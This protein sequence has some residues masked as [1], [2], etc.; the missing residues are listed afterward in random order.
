[1][2]AVPLAS[3]PPLLLGPLPT[4]VV[5]NILLRLSPLERVQAECTCRGWL[6]FLRAPV[7]LA[8]LDVEA[9][10]T[11]L[12]AAGLCDG[13]SGLMQHAGAA[14]RRVFFSKDERTFQA[15]VEYS[16][17]F[18]MKTLVQHCTEVEQL[19]LPSQPC[20]ED[21]VRVMLANTL[22]LAQLV[23]QLPRLRECDFGTIHVS[24]K[25]LDALLPVL[26]TPLPQ[27][28]VTLR[29]QPNFFEL[30]DDEVMDDEQDVLGLLAAALS[31]CEWRNVM[32]RV[33]KC[34]VE[35]DSVATLLLG[36]VEAL[37]P[38]TVVRSMYV[39]LNLPVEQARLVAR[40][41]PTHMRIRKWN[42]TCTAADVAHLADAFRPG[43]VVNGAL[44]LSGHWGTAALR[45]ALAALS[46][47]AEGAAAVEETSQ[48][49]LRMDLEE[50]EDDWSATACA[51]LAEWLRGN[52]NVI[53][54]CLLA[55]DEA[56]Q[57]IIPELPRSLQEIEIRSCHSLQYAPLM[58]SVRRGELPALIRL[59]LGEVRLDDAILLRD[60]LQSLS[61][62]STAA[63]EVH[64]SLADP[65]A[66]DD[67]NDDV[68]RSHAALLA[69]PVVCCCYADPATALLELLHAGGF[70]GALSLRE[71]SQHDLISALH[72][73]AAAASRGV[74]LPYD[75]PAMLFLLLLAFCD[76]TDVDGTLIMAPAD[77]TMHGTC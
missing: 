49:G 22:E 4:D 13:L 26:H 31:N 63:L 38:T 47:C 41:A 68:M 10:L 43:V 53:A 42:V 17:M 60:E 72:H 18:A 15:P 48:L 76:T 16:L 36:F 74:R 7:L 28:S 54:L 9:A 24:R 23:A 46:A 64:Y 73:G 27:S 71:S 8:E 50:E 33:P 55:T 20:K 59:E 19:R 5:A 25:H 44:T 56:V 75:V 29:L 62:P 6:Q 1:M 21:S 35:D 77:M 45:T 11:A 58:Q 39:E 66:D 70:K 2:A 57:L 40:A 51:P 69:A 12:H 37:Q 65:T 67:D 14:L 32:V 3:A 30:D 52:G 34:I 61:L